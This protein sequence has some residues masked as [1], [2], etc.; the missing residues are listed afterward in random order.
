MKYK[1]G[2][3]ILIKS[4]EWFSNHC[5]KNKNGDYVRKNTKFAMLEKRNFHLCDTIVTIRKV[6]QL[7][8]YL[9]L[10][11]SQVFENWMFEKRITENQY[12]V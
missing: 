4:L 9:I 10:T 12:E 1:V 8:Y 7:K 6:F 11:D 5:E 3:T 2:D